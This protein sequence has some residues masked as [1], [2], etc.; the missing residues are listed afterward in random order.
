[1]IHQIKYSHIWIK[2]KEKAVVVGVEVK[3]AEEVVPL[4]LAEVE[5]EVAEEVVPLVLTGVDM[6]D[7]RGR[8]NL[9]VNLKVDQKVAN[10]RPLQQPQLREHGQHQ[11]L[12]QLNQLWL[13]QSLQF[14][15]CRLLVSNLT[16]RSFLCF[17]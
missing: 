15:L 6:G 14:L 10:R 3:V 9:K 13:H 1:L 2:E 17:S 7:S 5:G 11:H 8:V 12:S 4:V 16:I